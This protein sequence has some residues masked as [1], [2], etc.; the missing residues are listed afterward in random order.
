[1]LSKFSKALYNLKQAPYQKY[2][3]NDDFLIDQTVLERCI[4]DQCDYLKWNF[5]MGTFMNIALYSDD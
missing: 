3:K 4:G 2:S 5:S 1:M